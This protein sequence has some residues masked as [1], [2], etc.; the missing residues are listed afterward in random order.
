MEQEDAQRDATSRREDLKYER[1]E[2][3]KAQKAVLDELVPRAEPGTRARQLEKKALVNEKMKSFRERSPGAVEVPESELMGGGDSL[4]EFKQKKQEFERKK[5]EREIRKE[6]ILRARAEERDERLREYRDKEDKTMAIL[7][8][9][10][11]N[12]FGGS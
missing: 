4:T 5:N 11:K 2:D 3:R 10:A 6:E 1:S 7:K 9:L 8:A 12:R